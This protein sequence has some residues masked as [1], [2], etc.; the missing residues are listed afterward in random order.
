MGLARLETPDEGLEEGLTRAEAFLGTPDYAAPE[1]AE[2]SRLADIRADL[3]SLGATWFFLLTGE[4]P[5][6]GMSLMQKLRRQLTQPTPLVTDHRP[7]VPPVLVALIRKLMDRDPAQAVPDAGRT[8][9]RDRRLSARPVPDAGLD[10][11]GVRMSL[12][13]SRPMRGASRPSA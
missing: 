4:V 10:V 9:R 12:W 8:R 11:R 7:D 1:Q 13:S 5:F 6:P 3:Y 2:D